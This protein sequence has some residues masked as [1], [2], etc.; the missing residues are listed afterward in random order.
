MCPFGVGVQDFVEGVGDV[1]TNAYPSGP[2]PGTP[3]LSGPR[4][5][6]RR[7][8][9]KVFC[10]S[11]L[12][13]SLD[14]CRSTGR[15][16]R[17]KDSVLSEITRGVENPCLRTDGREDKRPRLGPGDWSPPLMTEGEEV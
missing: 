7:L 1:I 2:R 13:L 5:D 11:S 14:S 15:V 16:A 17:V 9:I 4:P 12:G 8:F 10:S 3:L 6:G